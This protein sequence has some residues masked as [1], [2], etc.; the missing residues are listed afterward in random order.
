M[1]PD[2]LGAVTHCGPSVDDFE[3]LHELPEELASVLR[4]INGFIL[5]DG[6][7]HVRGAARDPAWH[8]LRHAMASE[9]AFA[10]LY[11]SVS[12]TDIPF[13]QDCMGDQ[14]LLREGRV[15]SLRAET[16]E[17]EEVSRTLDDFWDAIKYDAQ[18]F[19]NFDPNRRL[20][21]GQLLHAYP[22]LCTQEAASGVSL[23]PA[24]ALELIR[25][26]ANFAKFLQSFPEGT[27]FDV[28]V[29]GKLRRSTP[30]GE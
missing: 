11:P 12:R 3:L 30:S 10:F 19:L 4:E 8:S 17:V 22:P 13:A 20:Q 16:G 23:R 18:E 2:L 15:L 7:L 1:N 6:A 5:F 24:P 27:S 29:Y 14:F 9:D 21:P 26:H 28:K 25:H